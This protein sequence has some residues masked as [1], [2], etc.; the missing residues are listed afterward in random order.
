MRSSNLWK[1]FFTLI[2]TRAVSVGSN[3]NW[4]WK[5]VTVPLD[6]FINPLWTL[7]NYEESRGTVFFRFYAYILVHQLARIGVIFK[8]CKIFKFASPPPLRTARRFHW[9][10]IV[11]NIL[12]GSRTHL[13][14]KHT[15]LLR[16]RSRVRILHILLTTRKSVRVVVDCA[17]IVSA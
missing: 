16:L 9:R 6:W 4:V 12:I 14:L 17:D 13:I 15:K 10:E 3:S 1:Q 5:K 7:E 2:R 11:K 8:Y